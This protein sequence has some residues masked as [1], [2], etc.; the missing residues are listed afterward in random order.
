MAA[1][2]QLRGPDEAQGGYRIVGLQPPVTGHVA[3][4]VA[5]ITRLI[6]RLEWVRALDIMC[7]GPG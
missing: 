3:A 5:D 2:E 1:V 4:A 7:I 6:E